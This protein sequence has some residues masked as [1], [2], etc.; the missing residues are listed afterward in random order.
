MNGAMDRRK[1]S[2][3]EAR[4]LQRT[5]QA[6]RAE[7]YREHPEAEA[8]QQSKSRVLKFL[9][10]YCLLLSL[11]KAVLMGMNGG[12]IAALV[13]GF[14]V[15]FGM[16]TIFLAA[17]MGPKW[18]LAFVLY[19]WALYNVYRSVDSL[20]GQGITSTSELAAAYRALFAAVPAAAVLDLLSWVFLV[21]VLLTAAWLT[22]P[23]KNRRLAEECEA[24]EEQWKAYIASNPVEKF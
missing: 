17:G 21:L 16:N 9:L 13:V 12:L 15:G 22:L 10:L 18:K 3:E 23:P 11:G 4:E 20:A 7:L 5:Y 6:R 19:G 8:F 2:P 24:L 1:M 14:L